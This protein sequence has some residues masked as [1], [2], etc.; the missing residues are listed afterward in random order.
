MYARKHEGRCTGNERDTVC[1]QERTPCLLR[2]L[3][4]DWRVIT[5]RAV[6][7]LVLAIAVE[8]R[9]CEEDL[10]YRCSKTRRCEEEWA[11]ARL[12]GVWRPLAQ[13]QRARL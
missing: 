11:H 8:T 5:A 3:T 10:G 6:P 2:S 12:R 9:R 7:T 1:V 4:P 13:K